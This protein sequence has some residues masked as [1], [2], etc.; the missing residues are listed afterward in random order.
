MSAGSAEGLPNMAQ[1][2]PLRWGGGLRGGRPGLLACD[3]TVCGDS[4]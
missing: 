2:R 4:C 1:A 3:L